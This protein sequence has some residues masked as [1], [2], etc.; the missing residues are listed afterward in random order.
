MVPRPFGENIDIDSDWSFNKPTMKNAAKLI[1]ISTFALGLLFTFLTNANISSGGPAVFSNGTSAVISLEDKSKTPTSMP[2]VMKTPTAAATNTSAATTTANT[3]NNAPTNTS[4]ASASSG[5]KKIT[6]SFT[7]SQNSFTEYGDVAFDHENHAEKNYSADGKS[8]VACI[9]CHHTDQP[10]SALKAPLVT[11]ERDETLTMA[12]YQ[13]SSQ[14][15]STCRSC[16][17]NENEI[18]EGKTMPVLKKGEREIKLD[19]KEAYHRNCNDCHDAAVRLRMEVKKTKGFA[20]SNDC[21]VCHK[22]NN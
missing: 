4:T 2:T 12:E 21:Y 22:T 11:S 16:H 5:G 10:K 3:A 7:L 20:A 6:K 18:P 19:N 15:V 9:E 13:K 17:Y 1:V 8:V 14:K